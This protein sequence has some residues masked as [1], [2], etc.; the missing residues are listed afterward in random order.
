MPHR[1]SAAVASTAAALLAALAGGSPASATT[2][3]ERQARH[4]QPD[5][6][7]Q[8][9]R[10]D[11]PRRRRLPRASPASSCSAEASASPPS[12]SSSSIGPGRPR[13]C[14]RS[15]AT[16]SSCCATARTRTLELRLTI[17][18]GGHTTV[19]RERRALELDSKRC[20]APRAEAGAD[21][22]L[23]RPSRR[24][25]T[26]DGRAGRQ[27]RGAEGRRLAVPGRHRGR[28]HLARQADGRRRLRRQLHRQR[29]ACT[30]RFRCARSSSATASRP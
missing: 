5:R 30:T 24:P 13:S 28:R 19:V 20:A 12:A 4:V 25:P 26:P 14:C 9:S 7:G 16:A 21:R 29:T 10:G 17:H 18:H 11:R 3:V 23:R 6:A 22:R 27:A 15:R 1:S 2:A 8:G